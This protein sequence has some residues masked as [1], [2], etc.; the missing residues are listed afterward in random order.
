MTS[1]LDDPP[2]R[3]GG[4]AAR[5]MYWTESRTYE[6]QR[7]S[8]DGPRR[9]TRCLGPQRPLSSRMEC[10]GRKVVLGRRSM[11]RRL[12][13][14]GSYMRSRPL[15]H[16]RGCGQRGEAGGC[17]ASAPAHLLRRLHAHGSQMRLRPLR[18]GRRC[19]QCVAACG[20][21]VAN[22]TGNACSDASTSTGV[23]GDADHFET[24]GDA[25]SAA[26]QAAGASPTAPA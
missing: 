7:D 21:S 15:R 2:G 18:H 1:C 24:V 20:P 8:L 3:A 4:A 16:E 23:S 5:K 14:R 22:G 12:R 6:I 19:E 17:I 13:M 26:R 9:G 10:H 11:L 25:S